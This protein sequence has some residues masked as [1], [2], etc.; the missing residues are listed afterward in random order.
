[1]GG[2][3]GGGGEPTFRDRVG[4]KRDSDWSFDPLPSPRIQPIYFLSAGVW[5]TFRAVRQK[6]WM[7]AGWEE[8]AVNTENPA[9]TPSLGLSTSVVSGSVL[10]P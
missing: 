8:G 5:Q 2:G 10:G 1:M 4:A 9:E 6:V 3:V 7:Q